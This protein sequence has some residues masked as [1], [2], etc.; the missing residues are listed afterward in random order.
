MQSLLLLLL[1]LLL[2]L[3]WFSAFATTITIRF[4][5]RI[6]QNPPSPYSRAKAIPVVHWLVISRTDWRHMKE[7]WFLRPALFALSLA[8]YL[9]LVYGGVTWPGPW[10]RRLRLATNGNNLPSH[11]VRGL[12][13]NVN[14]LTKDDVDKDDDDDGDE[15][16]ANVRHANR[17]LKQVR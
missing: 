3:L 17:Y 15:T 14:D 2:H 8:W 12:T 9:H 7:I 4:R 6:R 5:F 1:L 13:K 11:N 16:F 10:L